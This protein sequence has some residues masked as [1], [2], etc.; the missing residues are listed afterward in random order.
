MSWI[1]VLKEKPVIGQYVLFCGIA[2]NNDIRLST[3]IGLYA[4]DNIFIELLFMSSTTLVPHYL[5]LNSKK[6]N[7]GIVSHWMPVPNAEEAIPCQS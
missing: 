5:A 3:K 1:N 6:L 7:T 4:G 2:Q